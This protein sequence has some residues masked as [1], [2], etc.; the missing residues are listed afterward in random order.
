MFLGNAAGMSKEFLSTLILGEIRLLQKL[1]ATGFTWS[2]K[3]IGYDLSYENNIG[4]PY[5]VFLDR[6][7]ITGVVRGNTIYA[8]RP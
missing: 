8:T 4:F 3:V 2:P 1:E 5:A 7:Q 6:R